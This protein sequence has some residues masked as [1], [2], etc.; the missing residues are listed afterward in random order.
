MKQPV[1]PARR[2]E[3]LVDAPL[4]RR[5]CS[6]ADTIGVTNYT[7]L[8]TVGGRG[9]HGVWRQDEISGATAKLVFL[10][11]TSVEKADALIAALA[12]LL[13]SHDLLLTVDDVSVVRRQIL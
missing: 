5:I 12:P 9:A 8:P 2:V 6:A 13:D 7:L 1:F 3:I 11:I 4:V 10:T